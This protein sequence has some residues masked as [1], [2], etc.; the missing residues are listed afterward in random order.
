MR[1]PITMCHGTNRGPFFMPS[2]HWRQRPPL[3]VNHFEGYLRIASELGFQSISYDDLANVRTGNT[4]LP[5]RPMMFDF[6]HPNAS[7]R[8]EIWPLMQRYGFAG[9]LFI[10]TAPMEQVGDRR[11]MTWEEIKELVS[12]GWHIGSH[13]HNHYNMSYLGKKDPSGALIRAQ[14]EKCDGIL[15]KELGLVSKDFAYT[16]TTWSQ[17][18][19][20]EVRK[21]YRFAR[22]WI[23]GTHYETDSGCT[24]YADLVGVEGADEDDG[25]PP[26]A[27]RY[28]IPETDPYKLPSMELEYLIYEH[29]AFR[30]YLEGALEAG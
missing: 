7:I 21:R 22:L 26:Y 5:K 19:E 1:I 20:N 6:D 3:D 27:A 2:P 18:A 12:S 16:T 28:I 13:M 29:D 9:N 4:T 15:E 10:N 17:V 23:I 25:G 8:H 30:R 14:L 11:Y 24:R